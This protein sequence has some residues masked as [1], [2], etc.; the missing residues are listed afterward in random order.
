MY[1][2]SFLS[3]QVL[4][5]T[6]GY[7]RSQ[8]YNQ[9]AFVNT[10]EIFCLLFKP[11]DF[12]KFMEINDI[13]NTHTWGTDFLLGHFKIK[14]AIYYKFVVNHVLPS[15]TNVTVAQKEMETYLRKHGFNSIREILA[16]Y[17]S[18]YSTVEL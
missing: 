16:S 2:I 9:I 13:E 1:D 8:N 17:P 15:K 3:P 10:V 7:M 18:I 5:G 11:G 4:G 6:W 12:Y 14:T